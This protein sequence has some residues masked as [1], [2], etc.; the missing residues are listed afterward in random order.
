MLFSF[1]IHRTSWMCSSLEVNRSCSSRSFVSRSLAR[2]RVPTTRERTRSIQRHGWIEKDLH[3][4]TID[5]FA[6][7]SMATSRSFLHSSYS[8]SRRSRVE[9]S[10]RYGATIQQ[11]EEQKGTR[12]SSM[13]GG[14]SLLFPRMACTPSSP[15]PPEAPS[16]DPTREGGERWVHS[17]CQ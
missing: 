9:L 4:L 11:H 16:N 10:E 7:L 13:H 3:S 12:V 14:R 1:D 2:W 8:Y 15:L 6:K 5:S 17:T